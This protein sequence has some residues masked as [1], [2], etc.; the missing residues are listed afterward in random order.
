MSPHSAHAAMLRERPAIPA[1]RRRVSNTNTDA[2]AKMRAYALKCKENLLDE[3]CT[4]VRQQFR[5]YLAYFLENKSR[6]GVERLHMV[7]ELQR[8][9]LPKMWKM[10]EK[11]ISQ[12]NRA[13]LYNILGPD[14]YQ[15]YKHEICMERGWDPDDSSLIIVEASRR[16]GKTTATACAATSYL[17]IGNITMYNMAGGKPVAEQFVAIVGNNLR[18]FPEHEQRILVKNVGVIELESL[19]DENTHESRLQGL[20]AQ[21]NSVSVRFTQCT[22][23]VHTLLLSALP[24]LVVFTDCM[25]CTLTMRCAH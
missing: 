6:K 10:Q 14:D 24:C 22:L 25:L 17:V 15:R 9:I 12:L 23:T 5:T 18:M 2:V 4:Y 3:K 8:L 1:K 7:E 11:L 16:A 13:N 19:D 20:A 21:G